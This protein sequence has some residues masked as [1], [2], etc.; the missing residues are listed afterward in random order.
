MRFSFL[1]QGFGESAKRKPLLS[2]AF[3]LL[4]FPKKQGLEGQG[5]E[6]KIKALAFFKASLA[7]FKASLAFFSPGDKRAV[8]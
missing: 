4:V 8:S 6:K 2:S 3:P 5:K 7:F 1:F